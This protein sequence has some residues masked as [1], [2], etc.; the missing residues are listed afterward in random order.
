[1]QAIQTGKSC[2]VGVPG[3]CPV[4]VSGGFCFLCWDRLHASP[5]PSSP[6]TSYL[7]SFLCIPEGTA[8]EHRT[9][10]LPSEKGQRG[11]PG[12]QRKGQRKGSS[13]E[14][15]QGG[16]GGSRLRFSGKLQRQEELIAGGGLESSISKTLGMSKGSLAGVAGILFPMVGVYSSHCLPVSVPVCAGLRILLTPPDRRKFLTK[17]WVSWGLTL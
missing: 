15:Q 11:P 6:I 5:T 1:M 4:W 10:L 7:L 8:E 3:M 17:C 2:W 9:H 12:G 16:Q 13:G 14:R